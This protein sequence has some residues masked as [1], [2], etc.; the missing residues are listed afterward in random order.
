MAGRP[1]ENWNTTRS[2]PNWCAAR[3]WV[4]VDTAGTTA[5]PAAQVRPEASAPAP[6][7]VAGAQ[8]REAERAAW[9]ARLALAQQT[10][11]AYR[12]ATRY[13]RSSQP[14]AV[15]R[16]AH[17]EAPRRVQACRALHEIARI[18]KT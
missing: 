16:A 8:V 9:L 2:W 17:G 14:L 13:P 15:V 11:A 18:S 7:S 5:V 12:D 6:F 3:I 4:S 1:P 10:F